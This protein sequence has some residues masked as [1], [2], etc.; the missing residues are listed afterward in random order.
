MSGHRVDFK[1]TALR[2][3]NVMVNCDL[4]RNPTH[5]K[6]HPPHRTVAR[7]I[8]VQLHCHAV[9]GQPA[10]RTG[11]GMQCARRSRVRCRRREQ[12]CS[13][14]ATRCPRPSFPVGP[15]TLSGEGRGRLTA[16]PDSLPCLRPTEGMP[17]AASK[18]CFGVE[19]RYEEHW[20][21]I[22]I[23]MSCSLVPD[24]RSAAL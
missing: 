19:P 23:P 21:R 16:P 5:L 13:L 3:C 7:R 11:L 9:G 15:H 22:C 20:N 6:Q 10:G 12:L 14:E 4:P 8:R 18:P 1:G 17:V 2:S 24:P